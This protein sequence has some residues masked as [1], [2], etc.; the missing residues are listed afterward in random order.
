[1]TETLISFQQSANT[2]YNM[3]DVGHL[4]VKVFKAQG[5]ASADIGG[6]S[7]PFC[8]VELCN[9]RVLTHTEYKT[10]TPSWHKVFQL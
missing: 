3:K 4:M 10:L 2:F 6:K 1:M 7:D 5:L 8:V 9:D